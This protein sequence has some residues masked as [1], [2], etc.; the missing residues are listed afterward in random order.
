MAP[1]A[2]TTQRQGHPE[3]VSLAGLT[4]LLG[5]CIPVAGTEEGILGHLCEAVN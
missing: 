4:H 2:L 1:Q 5:G 3:R